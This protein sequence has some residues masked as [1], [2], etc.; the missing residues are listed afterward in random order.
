MTYRLTRDDFER[1]VHREFA[2]LRDAGS[3]AR[4]SSGET[5][6]FWRASTGPTW[7][8]AFTVTSTART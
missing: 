1:V 7:E 8:S 5:M 2:F 3:A 4:R 6:G